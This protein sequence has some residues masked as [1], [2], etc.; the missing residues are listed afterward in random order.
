V[1]P[2][3]YTASL[4]PAR[5]SEPTSFVVG[6][7]DV[8]VFLTAPVN[9]AGRVTVDDG[10]ALPRIDDSQ[11][12]QITLNANPTAPVKAGGVFQF[13][14]ASGSFTV[15]IRELPFG[16]YV[17]SITYG[18]RNLLEENLTVSKA[19]TADVSIVLTKTRPK[20]APAGVLV[21]GRLTDIPQGIGLGAFAVGMVGG[22]EDRSATS[23]VQPDGTFEFQ[24]V[25][26]GLYGVRAIV[27]QGGTLSLHG[28]GESLT[29][30]TKGVNDLKVPIVLRLEVS[31][32]ITLINAM[33]QPLPRLPFGLAVE[34]SRLGDNSVVNAPFEVR[35]VVRSGGQFGVISLVSGEYSVRLHGIPRESLKS[36]TAGPM[37]LLKVPLNV[38]SALAAGISLVAV[39]EETPN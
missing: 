39:V 35:A 29:V 3:N 9:Y 27:W 18:A 36:L 30:S 24:D 2:G 33:G 14:P 1:P 23:D 21:K 32:R 12:P 7:H 37:D 25:P 8:D 11:P 28:P 10:T 4:Q 38:D 31:G 5:R 20:T 19:P 34:F 17:R 22:P 13:D 26:P 16:Y 6:D 15:G